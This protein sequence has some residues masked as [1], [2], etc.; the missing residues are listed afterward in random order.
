MKTAYEVGL[1]NWN[2]GIYVSILFAII[3]IGFLIYRIKHRREIKTPRLGIIIILMLSLIFTVISELHSHYTQFYELKSGNYKT[4]E[5]EISN[6]KRD[7]KGTQYFSINGQD[8][9]MLSNGYMEQPSHSDDFAKNL[10]DNK[11]LVKI[12]YSGNQILK[13]EYQE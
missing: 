3:S 2:S 5:G 13:V 4:I 9:K 12:Y 6:F 10:S 7:A 1:F 11:Y 8:F